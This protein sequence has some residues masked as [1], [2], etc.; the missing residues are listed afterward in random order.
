[1]QK[2]RFVPVPAA[3]PV[4][5]VTRLVMHSSLGRIKLTCKQTCL[6]G[7]GCLHGGLQVEFLLSTDPSPGGFRA[8]NN[9]R[10][11]W[12]GCETDANPVPL[13][14]VLVSLCVFTK[15]FLRNNSDHGHVVMQDGLHTAIVPF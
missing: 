1:M 7:H 3:A 2:R 9:F 10:L 13:H 12:S 8:K 11:G 15:S 4:I 14:A 6:L 5:S